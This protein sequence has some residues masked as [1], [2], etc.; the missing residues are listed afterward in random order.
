MIEQAMQLI[1]RGTDEIVNDS[2]LRQKL[3][4]AKEQGRPLIVKE[5]VDPTAPEIHFGHTVTFR[6]LR[7][8]Q[9]LGHD[10]KFL[11]GD[12]TARIGDP[13]GRSNSRQALTE[14]EVLENA[15]TY[16]AQVSKILDPNRTE[17]V[18]NSSWLKPMELEDFVSLL[19]RGTINDLIKRTSVATRLANGE[20]VTAVEMIYPFLQGFDSVELEADVEIGGTDQRYNFLF[21]RDLQR[22]Y[23]QEPQ[24]CITMPL[25]IG[26]DGIQKMSKS[27]GN[28]IGVDENPN[29]MY[30]KVMSI[31]DSLM[32]N[33]FELLTD[34]PMPELVALEGR[35]LRNEYHPKEAK[36]QLA[37]SI[38]EQ[39]HSLDQALDAEKE[40]Q[41]V[42]RDQQAPTV[43]PELKVSSEYI[44]PQ[45][46]SLID[47][48]MQAGYADSRSA[49]RRKIQQGGVRIND[50]KITDFNHYVEPEDG[51][52]LRV[53]RRNFA[54][55]TYES[56]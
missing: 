55:L 41:R 56:D 49:A 27:L 45:G 8:F 48:V 7:H 11:I 42:Y 33:W 40:F 5:G 47:L 10:V 52:V 38:V 1:G 51:Q 31:P 35:V 24:V 9:D 19:Y 18:Q 22:S 43:I 3:L 21:A 50:T 4:R 2:E 20:T 16:R 13:T 25:L 54:R 34:L 30:G 15:K 32:F 17:F 12:F 28:H 14:A 23:G 39:F 26:T 6:K 29:D 46:T 36:M 44:T 53:G 37:R